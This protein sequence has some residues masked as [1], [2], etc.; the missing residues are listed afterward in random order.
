LDKLDPSS[1]ELI[2]PE[3]EGYLTA[4]HLW[5]AREGR[6]TLHAA[7][8]EFVGFQVLLRGSVPTAIP[9]GGVQ[10][11]LAFDG[12]T[13]R[14][15]QVELGRYQTV[16][17]RLGPMPDPIVPLTF[18]TSGPSGAKTQSFHV[19]IYVPHI[20][21]AGQYRGTLIVKALPGEKRFSRPSGQGTL[22]FP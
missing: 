7:K 5:N 1:G 11:A 21:P 16:N 10:L 14:S 4:N 13:G 2:P 18:P 17:T 19:E 3:P 8:N 22:R 20:V 12:A 15:L 6:I 9:S